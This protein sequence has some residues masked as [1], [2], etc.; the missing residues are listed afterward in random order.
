M[1]YKIYRNQHVKEL[2]QTVCCSLKQDNIDA[3][4]TDGAVVSIYTSN[5]YL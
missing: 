4:L 5:K 2:A 3:V 1:I